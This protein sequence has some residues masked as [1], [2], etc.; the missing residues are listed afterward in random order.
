MEGTEETSPRRQV[1]R[2]LRKGASQT[3]GCGGK[4]FCRGSSP[5]GTSCKVD[6]KMQTAFAG[7]GIA[8]RYLWMEEWWIKGDE[9]EDGLGN[10]LEELY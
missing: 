1:S 3:R 6:A 8:P 10:P 7:L 4:V 5:R 9:E 2:V